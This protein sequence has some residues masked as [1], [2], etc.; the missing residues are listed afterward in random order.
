MAL[1]RNVNSSVQDRIRGIICFL[2]SQ[3]KHKIFSGLWLRAPK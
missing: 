3:I 1:Y 2:N